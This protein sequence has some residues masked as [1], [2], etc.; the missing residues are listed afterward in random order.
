MSLRGRSSPREINL[1]DPYPICRGTPEE[2]LEWND[3]ADVSHGPPG[4][5]NDIYKNDVER[6]RMSQGTS[7]DQ[8]VVYIGVK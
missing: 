4:K 8:K 3:V 1:A 6:K 7:P 5:Q 2:P